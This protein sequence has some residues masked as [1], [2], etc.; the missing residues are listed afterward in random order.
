MASGSS[1]PTI[2]ITDEKGSTV[3]Q[4][5][6]QNQESHTWKSRGQWRP[7]NPTASENSLKPPPSGLFWYYSENAVERLALR[8]LEAN[9]L[10]GCITNFFILLVALAVNQSYTQYL[11]VVASIILCKPRITCFCLRPSL[12][13]KHASASDTFR[14]FLYSIG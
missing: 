4:R 9:E 11:L 14:Q 12:R 1:I 2:Q 5:Q 7:N 10:S 6:S 8:H 3:V 13:I